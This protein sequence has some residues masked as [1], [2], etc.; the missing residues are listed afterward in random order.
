VIV[1]AHWYLYPPAG[2][3]TD[4]WKM[5]VTDDDVD[6]LLDALGRE[7]VDDAYLTTDRPDAFVLHL[8]VRDGWGYLAWS[9]DEFLGS[10][11]GDP[12]SP[13]T[14]GTFNTDYFPGTGLA[15]G[16]LAPVLKELL[17]TGRRPTG[18]AWVSDD[19]LTAA[20]DQDN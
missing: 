18:V 8:A 3:R 16:A 19:E 13:G 4:E 5:L 9:D 17:A 11:V 2:P 14:H 1:R 6:E 15:V 20:M 10:P 7:Y 12:R